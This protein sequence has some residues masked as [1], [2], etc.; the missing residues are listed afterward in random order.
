MERMKDLRQQLVGMLLASLV[1]LVVAGCSDD[2]GCT[3]TPQLPATPAAPTGLTQIAFG[4]GTLQ[5]W[6]YTGATLDGT[7]Q[8]PIN[9]VF[10]GHATPIAIRAALVALDGDR[11]G[12]GFPPVAPFD[13]VWT[14]ANGDVQAAYAGDEGWTANVIQLQLGGY[15]P[16]RVHL[17]LFGTGEAWGADGAW[18]L[19][20]AH[21]EVVIPG[22]ADHQV[23]NWELAEQVVVA[24]L[25]RSGLLDPEN[26]TALTAVITEAPGFREIPAV[27]YN[28]LPVELRG[29]I[30]GPLE[31]VTEPVPIG[32]DGQATILNL[33]QAAPIV[34]G[35][36]TENLAMAYGQLIP[37]PF[38]STGAY[39]YV[40]VEGPIDFRKTAVVEPDG[41][42]HYESS[43]WGQ[44]TVTP[45]DVTVDPPVPSGTPFTAI[46]SDT[47]VGRLE[48]GRVT[49]MVQTKRVSMRDE[50]AEYLQLDLNLTTQGDKTFR[51]ET[52]CLVPGVGQ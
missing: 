40:Y 16:L 30:N 38:C 46:V 11:T 33:A 13:G 39:D 44:I 32:T 34:D 10:V 43:Y 50:G 21:F 51:T 28:G 27:I 12:V 41:R 42:Y 15:G 6:P 35:A 20:G 17:R 47:Q 31:D 14:E 22:T 18:T 37:R 23:L 29:L 3:C 48:E 19:G 1:V 24:D 45:F 36:F 9:L 5:C 25:M 8:D 4:G 2:E 52:S 26:A 7:P 49:M